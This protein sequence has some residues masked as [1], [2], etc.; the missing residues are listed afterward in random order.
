MNKFRRKNLYRIKDMSYYNYLIKGEFEIDK[1]CMEKLTF[2]NTEINYIFSIIMRILYLGNIHFIYDEN[3][4][5]S[6]ID[7]EKFENASYFL[8][9]SKENLTIILSIL[10]IEQS[11]KGRDAK[12]L[13][14]KMFDYIVGKINRTIANKEKKNKINKNNIYKIGLLFFLAWKILITI[15]LNNCALITLMKNYN[16]ILIIIYLNWNRLNKIIKKLFENKEKKQKTNQINYKTI[17]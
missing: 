7:P 8:G 4:I 9:I 16:N 15:L 3:N 5:H 17:H 10:N 12:E 11:I 6:K 1:K 14:S 13:Y 2:T